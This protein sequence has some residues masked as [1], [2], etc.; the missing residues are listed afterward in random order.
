MK[1]QNLHIVWTEGENLSL[2][3]VLSCSL[4]KT[5]QDERRPRTIEIPDSIKFFMTLNQHTQPIQCHYAVSKEYVTT[6]TTNT[7]V[8]S[9]HFPIYLQIEESYF[10]VQLEN[11]LYLFV[12]HQE[13]K[14]KPQPLEQM[15]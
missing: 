13:F 8:E 10:K 1:F 15:L 2:P 11:D 7:T 12:S 4:S 6:V 3:D 14:T 9:P 5:T